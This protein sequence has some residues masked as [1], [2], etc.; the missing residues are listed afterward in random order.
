[1]PPC[2]VSVVAPAIPFLQSAWSRSWP[3]ANWPTQFGITFGTSCYSA[4]GSLGFRN[5]A[6]AAA[7]VPD[8]TSPN[9][10]V[11]FTTC[12]ASDYTIYTVPLVAA[13]I[14]A[15]LDH[16]ATGTGLLW[17]VAPAPLTTAVTV[18]V[19]GVVVFAVPM[20]TLQNATQS[21]MEFKRSIVSVRLALNYATGPQAPSWPDSTN[22]L[23]AF[24]PVNDAL[25]QLEDLLNE[26]A[27]TVSRDMTG[28]VTSHMINS[29]VECEAAQVADQ[30]CSSTTLMPT[31]PCNACDTCCKCLVQQRCDGECSSCACVKC[32]TFNYTPSFV[33]A[34]AAAA[35]FIL[36]YIVLRRVS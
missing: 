33:A 31:G 19:A 22:A 8:W 27:D 7:L 10:K 16:R 2:T 24:V 23:W 1:M 17:P 3:T 30:T 34:C 11:S 25:T 13:Q 4:C 12:A 5:V 26:T 6:G 20:N 35:F 32:S 9:V 29:K 36:A 18:D 15:D 28:Y 21:E 14:T